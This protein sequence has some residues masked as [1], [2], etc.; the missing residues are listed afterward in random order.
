MMRV[1]PERNEP[2]AL[3]A[4]AGFGGRRVLEIGCGYGRLTRHYADQ[5]GYVVGID[6]F[7]PSIARAEA[8]L[9]RHLH[10]RVEFRALSL[11]D[12]AQAAAS[13]AFDIAILSWSL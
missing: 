10:G 9:P 5:A 12:F 1:D 7:A 13:P 8:E 11:E 3:F 2:E 4:L 6:P